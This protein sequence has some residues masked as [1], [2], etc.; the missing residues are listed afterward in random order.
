MTINGDEG[1]ACY[2]AKTGRVSAGSC[3]RLST[4]QAEP[5]TT[6]MNDTAKQAKFQAIKDLESA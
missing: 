6:M 3:L 4:H 2:K 5:C 1:G